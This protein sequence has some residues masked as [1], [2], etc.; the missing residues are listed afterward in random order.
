MFWKDDQRLTIRNAEEQDLNKLL[1]LLEEAAGWLHTKG[2]TQ[3]DYYLSDL[4]GNT[5]EV[6][7]SIKRRSTYVVE[8]EGEIAASVTLEDMPGDWDR[9]IWGEEADQGE[10]I[11][12]HR[13]VVKRKY[14]GLGIGDALI[15]WAKK[16]TRQ[17]GKS[18]LRFDCLNKNEGLNSYYQ[19]HYDLK[20]IA[21]IYGKHSKYEIHV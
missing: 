18:I 12:L 6:A 4:E 15:D 2:T 3:W 8:T 1:L 10:V 16:E 21:D 20:G 19:R 7:D 11:Y 9:D 14:A 5:D 17:R 13:L